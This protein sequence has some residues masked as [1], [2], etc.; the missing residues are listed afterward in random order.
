MRGGDLPSQSLPSRRAS[1]ARDARRRVRA[2][3]G[4]H[5]LDVRRIPRGRRPPPVVRESGTVP[6]S[7]W[8]RHRDAADQR[9]PAPR[10]NLRPGSS[11]RTRAPR[12]RERHRGER[13]DRRPRAERPRQTLR[14]RQRPRATP[15]RPEVAPERASS[16]QRRARM[17]PEGRDDTRPGEGHIPRRLDYGR[18]EAGAMEIIERLE[19]HRRGVYTGAIGY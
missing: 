9:D 4:T 13:D 11:T 12:K 7:P 8:L 2:P 10:S 14:I 19:P 15:E 17:P 1:A 3:P 5:A 16:G 6:P 18:S